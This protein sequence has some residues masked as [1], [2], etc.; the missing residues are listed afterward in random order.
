MGYISDWKHPKVP[1]SIPSPRLIIPITEYSYVAR[2]VRDKIPDE[3]EIYKKSK[4]KGAE[5][6]SW[7][8]NSKALKESDQ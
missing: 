6:V 8:F 1:N 4:V 7:F 2:D 5:K 3:Q